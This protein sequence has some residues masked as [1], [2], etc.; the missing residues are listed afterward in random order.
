MKK[1]KQPLDPPVLDTNTASQ[2]L[3]NILTACDAEPNTIPLSV[4]S[5]YSNYRKDR[6]LFQKIVLILIVLLFCMLPLFFVAPKFTIKDA[7]T[8]VNQPSY[9]VEVSSL[10]PIERIEAKINDTSLPVYETGEK[11]YSIEPTQNGILEVKVTLKNRQSV[12]KTYEVTTVDLSPPNVVSDKADNEHIYIYLEDDLS[13]IDYENITARDINGKNLAPLSYDQ[14]S[15]CVV[16]KYPD[17]TLNV[18]IPDHAGN[19]LQ[20]VLTVKE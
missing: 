20:I 17:S 9:E 10:F 15:N 12:T 4:L 13:G 8:K 2:M 1:K 6:Y 14:T 11:I 7:T 18:T 3:D 16:F 5:S 19:K